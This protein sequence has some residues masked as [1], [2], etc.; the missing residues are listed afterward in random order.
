[1]EIHHTLDMI[2]TNSRLMQL[3][4]PD[5]AVAII[6]IE[7]TIENLKGNMNICLPA[8]SLDEVF[9]VFNSKYVKLPK[10]EDPVLEEQRKL[11]I[12]RSLKSSPL[13]ISAMLGKTEI[14]LKDLLSLQAGDIIPL[15]TQVDKDS[16]VLEVESLPWFTGV[17]GTK[18][19]KY[20]VK[21]NKSLQ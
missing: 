14:S 6:A 3:V 10:K 11:G 17:I 9:R 12:M 8:S 7:I 20:A 2:E 16:I 19:K 1:M 5:E 13:N 21:I 18:Q 4:Q 15:N